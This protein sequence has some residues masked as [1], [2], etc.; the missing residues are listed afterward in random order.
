MQLLKDASSLAADPD[1]A[2]RELMDTVPAIMQFI[3]RHMRALR[4]QELTV[5]QIR[6]LYVVNRAQ[7]PSLSQVAEHIGLSLPAMSR[8]V[9]AMVRKGLMTRNACAEDRRHIRLALTTKGRA[10]MDAAW[11][12]THAELASE[13]TSL[14]PEQR[15]AIASAMIA[16]RPVFDPESVENS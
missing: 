3:R 7:R 9:D 15:G 1:S 5:P 4:G 10:A 13:L 14:S 12:G 6:T 16:L 11:Q 8:L 2:A